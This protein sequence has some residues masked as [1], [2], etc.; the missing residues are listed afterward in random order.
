MKK[1]LRAVAGIA[2]LAFG[3]SACSAQV[4]PVATAESELVFAN[5]LPAD[6]VVALSVP[7]LKRAQAGWKA[8]ALY[9]I[10]NEPDVQT[11]LAKPLTKLPP[12]PEL[13]S[14]LAKLEAIEARRFFISLVSLNTEKPQV[15]AGFAFKGDAAALD[16]LLARPKQEL[17]KKYPNGKVASVPFGNRTIET[18]D[19]ADVSLASTVTGG[20]YFISSDLSL[21]KAMLDRVDAKAD[22]PPA[23]GKDADFRAAVARLPAT[24]DA[25]TFVRARPIID[26]V[27]ALAEGTGRALP[28]ARRRDLEKIRAVVATSGFEKEKLRDTIFILAPGLKSE[29]AALALKSMPFTSPE[30]LLYLGLSV[31]IPEDSDVAAADPMGQLGKTLTEA[32]FNLKDLRA[33]FGNEAA[34]QVEWSTGALYPS[35]MVSV[36]MKDRATALKVLAAATAK[37]PKDSE[38]MSKTD[39]GVEYRILSAKKPGTPISPTLAV[40]GTHFIAGISQIDVRSAIARAKGNGLHLDAT[41]AFKT[42]MAEV[43]KPETSVFFLD[44]KSLFEKFYGLG[45]TYGPA[46]A[47]GNKQIEEV[48]D[49]NKLPPT[50]TISRHLS[51]VVWSQRFVEDGILCEST[52]PLTLNQLV[53]GGGVF[54]GVGVAA[55]QRMMKPEP[56]PTGP[57]PSAPIPPAPGA[58]PNAPSTGDK[59]P[60]LPKPGG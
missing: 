14:L 22:A 36:E 47:E 51:P 31:K 49:L 27:L 43:G 52:G 5:F 17:A 34:L 20:W 53:L 39:D 60:D 54:T 26:K 33:A 10:W 42:A 15:I 48:V 45:R 46:A 8:S 30:T 19:A 4:K 18:F 16:S 41:P 2:F 3:L 38:W 6:A 12:Q 55:Y 23:L 25:L 11:F 50:E 59:K 21:L 7:D 9:Q 29:T 13:S 58:S 56:A 40:T 57:A 24:H 37:P 28:E 1:P 35:P 44:T 32:G